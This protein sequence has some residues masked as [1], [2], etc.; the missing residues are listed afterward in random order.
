M[1]NIFFKKGSVWYRQHKSTVYFHH[2]TY[3][4]HI[5]LCKNDLVPKKETILK[6]GK[7]LRLCISMEFL[8]VVW[9]SRVQRERE[10][11][12]EVGDLWHFWD[13][14]VLR[15]H[16]L[17]IEL[18]MDADVALNVDLSFFSVCIDG[19]WTWAT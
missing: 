6:N 1:L 2:E 7:V 8:S 12:T 18:G 13:A 17:H 4:T 5:T 11:V 15:R 19:K 16:G 14:V 10:R 9:D 3:L